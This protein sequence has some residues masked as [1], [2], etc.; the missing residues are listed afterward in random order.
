MGELVSDDMLES[1]MNVAC[2][3]IL[4]K[5]TS[6][7]VCYA[8]DHWLNGTVVFAWTMLH[9]GLIEALGQVLQLR[10][11]QTRGDKKKTSSPNDFCAQSFFN[12][13]SSQ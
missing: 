12:P 8:L 4:L 11:L 1:V 13:A 2:Q 6:A 10:C 9:V 5:N 7:D 3:I